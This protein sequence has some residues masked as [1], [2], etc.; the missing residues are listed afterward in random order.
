MVI[1]KGM[2]WGYIEKWGNK[3]IS[4]LVFVLLAR[5]LEPNDFGIIVIARLI[6][7]YLETLAGQGLDYTVVQRKK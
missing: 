6:I 1:F 4:L 2:I 7:D 3:V 5:I